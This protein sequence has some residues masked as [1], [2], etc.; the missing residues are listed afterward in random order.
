MELMIR[1]VK[2]KPDKKPKLVRCIECAN[3]GEPRGEPAVLHC[4]AHGR[5]FVAH[6]VRKCPLFKEKEG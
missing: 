1:H 4:L 5:G 3:G 2:M 6:A